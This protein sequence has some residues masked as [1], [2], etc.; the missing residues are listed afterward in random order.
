MK[1]ERARETSHHNGRS[2]CQCIQTRRRPAGALLK[3]IVD[4]PSFQKYILYSARPSAEPLQL[5]GKRGRRLLV[6]PLGGRRR[7][8]KPDLGGRERG[9]A[10]S[11][12]GACVSTPVGADPLA[13]LVCRA[14]STVWLMGLEG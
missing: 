4:I 9:R 12:R 6:C 3:D 5:S 1:R 11:P 8:R 14:F 2:G 7:S 10:H 13:S